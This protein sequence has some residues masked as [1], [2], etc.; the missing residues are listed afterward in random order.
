[1]AQSAQPSQR[2]EQQARFAHP[3]LICVWCV[4]VC[5]V[6][7]YPTMAQDGD[8]LLVTYSVWRKARN[9]PIDQSGVRVVLIQLPQPIV[10]IDKIAKSAPKLGLVNVQPGAAINFKVRLVINHINHF[11]VRFGISHINHFKVRLG[12]NHINHFKVRLGINHINHFKVRLG[13]N[14]ISHKNQEYYE[15]LTLLIS[16]MLLI[17]N[18]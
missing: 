5:C 2:P 8:K 9:I 4:R 12:I 18:K 11:K 7:Q 15:C 13:I 3:I 6:L 17:D 10:G 1:V 16:L 14:H